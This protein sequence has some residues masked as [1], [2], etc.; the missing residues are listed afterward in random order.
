MSDAFWIS[1]FAGLPGMIAALASAY[2]LVRQ[3]KTQQKID[4]IK[5]ATDGMQRDLLQ[6]VQSEAQVRGWVAGALAAEKGAAPP[7]PPPPAGV[8][9]L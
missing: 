6:A 5:L 1:L 7:E 2:V 8:P 4:A 3:T 9:R